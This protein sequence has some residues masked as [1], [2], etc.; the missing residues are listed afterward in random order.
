[1][2]FSAH[3]LF[4]V[5]LTILSLPT[6]LWAQSAPKGAAK[7]P[8]GSI[9]GRVTLKGKGV[10][11]VAVALRKIELWNPN[12][13][14]P[15]AMTDQDGFYCIANVAPG[16]YEVSPSVPAFVPT[17]GREPRKNVLLSQ[18]ENVEN[19]DFALVRGGVITGRVT[20]ADGHPVIAQQVYIYRADAFQPQQPQVFP[21][22]GAQTDDRGIYRVF[23]LLPGKYKVAAGRSEKVFSNTIA[24][25][26][27]SYA[28]VFHPDATEDT[29]AAVIEVGE[30][31]EA[32]NVDI[33]LGR[34]L[35]TFSVAG[36]VVDS[37]KSVPVP[38]VRLSLQRRVGQRVES[39]NVVAVSNA[40][41]EFLAT[42]LI[43]GNY[44]GSLISAESGGM[45]AE[46]ITFDVIDQ[47]VSGI[48]VNLVQG[49][50]LSGLVVLETP[51]PAAVARFSE[52]QLH[53]F[54]N[55]FATRA[56]SS[57]SVPVAPDGSFSAT[58]LTGGL[59]NV[60][61]G[62]KTS[63]SSVP[64]KGFSL[65]RVERDG[66]V[67]SSGIPI[68]ERE[69]LTGVRVVLAYGTAT[70]RGVVE[71][72]NGTLP[73]GAWIYIGVLRPGE[74]ISKLRPPPVDARG[75]FLI[76]GVAAGTYVIL[77]AISGVP[78]LSRHVKREIT[79]QDG[80]TTDITL[81]IDMNQPQAPQKP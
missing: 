38:N 37:E 54:V 56:N 39:V 1:M 24:A 61:L 68:Q 34:A 36:R 11:G 26:R 41:G 81:T 57:G 32:T 12:D 18:A 52:L 4:A 74:R 29:K 40:Q 21:S 22:A 60:F 65:V 71:I 62:S 77:A 23:G 70:I 6:S 33:T 7:T 46:P 55:D 66:V 49:A 73:N 25:G 72:E 48:T 28:Q 42:G 3:Y 69:Q 19:I 50:S 75:R 59:A 58:G 9:S 20:D 51:S 44:R 76:E 30:G 63:I 16:N 27:S 64:P 17:D 78:N 31:T 5:L 80:V 43:P 45:R 79:V 10:F 2:S 53:V 15:R 47:D 13:R 14:V 35:P 67:M 8:S